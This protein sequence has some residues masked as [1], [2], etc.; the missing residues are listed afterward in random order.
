M[1]ALNKNQSIIVSFS[2]KG[3]NNQIYK[4]VS[5]EE[6]V[7]PTIS[8][9]SGFNF[10]LID[11][12]R[13]INDRMKRADDETKRK[14][15]SQEKKELKSQ[16]P[17]FSMAKF[18]NNYR[19]N[20]NFESTEHI[21]LDFDKV[22]NLDEV[23]KK[24]E[25][26]E[27]T[28]L[29]FTSVS[30]DGLKVGYWLESTITDDKKFKVVCSHYA[31]VFSGEYGIEADSTFDAARACFISNDPNI[32]VNYDC[33]RLSSKTGETKSP[34]DVKSKSGSESFLTR[35]PGVREGERH[36]SVV[37]HTGECIQ[38]GILEDIACLTLMEWNKKNVPP[39]EEDEVIDTVRD[40]Y[41]RYGDDIS[42]FMWYDEKGKIVF[43]DLKFKEYLENHGYY[44]Y[45]LKSDYVLVQETGGKVK[46]VEEH[47]L[48][49]SLI[50]MIADQGKKDYLICNTNKIISESKQDYIKT[51]DL[52]FN[53]DTAD[54]H[55]AYFKNGFFIVTEEDISGPHPYTELRKVI[56]ESKIINRE[57][58]LDQSSNCFINSEFNQFLKKIT[59]KDPARY[60]ALTTAI[61]YLCHSHF[62]P[63]ERK[64]IVAY[65]E[66]NPD[67]EGVA[68]GGKGKSIIGQGL[69]HY[70][71]NNTWIDGE[72]LEEIRSH[73]FQAVNPDTELIVID[74]LVMKFKFGKLFASITEGV[75]VEKK[76]KDPFIVKNVKFF[77]SSNFT[78]GGEGSSYERRLKEIE[79]AP[80]YNLDFS[81]RDEF[82]HLLFDDWND[83]QWNMFYNCILECIKT[84]L[85][86]GLHEYEKKNVTVKKLIDQTSED[87]Y[88][89]AKKLSLD[90]EYD[91]NEVWK[92]YRNE[93]GD[94]EMKKNKFTRW[95]GIFAD[96]MG[97]AYVNVPG[98]GNRNNKF[99]LI[100]RVRWS[101][102]LNI[103]DKSQGNS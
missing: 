26:D 75:T 43:S 42:R 11:R 13:D 85:S 101:G 68:E 14:G 27:R 78:L 49:E 31:K 50:N 91:K 98:T 81:P 15:F 47:Q 103:P 94:Y 77:I 37:K 58:R 53:E 88:E 100:K 62:D 12:I 61:G 66:T 45:P 44:K 7:V 99:K 36:T 21:I 76:Y 83:E 70:K 35:W 72:R 102:K 9:Y 24:I 93:T 54:K 87:F 96:K 1:E 2:D 17:H 10:W 79:I 82:G 40:V 56:W 22:N 16:L 73:T 41:H 90:V 30:G 84:Y 3:I 38:Q 74:D 32:Y 33:K 57:L 29:A 20:E 25:E 95:L 71:T 19:S 23:K 89:F 6:K 28:F 65:D 64:A 67:M 39:L 18:K 69:R 46:I 4:R 63:S 80:H 5:F 97:Y 60:F 8:N 92:D 86:I 59:K 34:A 51:F 48:K 55:Y 52:E